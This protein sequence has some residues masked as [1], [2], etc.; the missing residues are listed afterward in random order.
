VTKDLED[1]EININQI[2]NIPTKKFKSICKTKIRKIAFKY[3]ETKKEKHESVKLIHY[4][5]LNMANY[6]K[7]NSCNY[8]VQERQYLF[9]CRYSCK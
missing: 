8:S 6:L 1:L 7:E 9:Q 4:E 3:L 5:N 2:E